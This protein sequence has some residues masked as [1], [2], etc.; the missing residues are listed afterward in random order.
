MFLYHRTRP[1]SEKHR[2]IFDRAT[3][4][5]LA[6]ATALITGSHESRATTW[7]DQAAS[8]SKQGSQSRDG[9]PN[10]PGCPGGPGQ[11]AGFF[12]GGANCSLGSLSLGFV[13]STHEPH[14]YDAT[15]HHSRS[16]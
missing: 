7:M 1:S 5:V 15:R 2:L 8:H 4:C 11:R 12:A 10:H 13:H 14:T 9:S 3:P 16:C 6:G